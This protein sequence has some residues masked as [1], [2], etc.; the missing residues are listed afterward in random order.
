VSAS[1]V[2]PA[3]DAAATIGRTLECLGAQRSSTPFDVIVVDDGSSDD[4]ASIAE[5]A[6]LEVRVVRQGRR[7]A[8]EARNRGV[9]ESAGEVLAFLDA[10]CFPTPGWLEAGVLALADADVVQGKVLP[11]AGAELGPFDRTLWITENVGLWQTANLFVTREVFDRVGGFEDWL[12]VELGKLMAEDL[13]FGW[14]ATR[15]GARPGFCEGA[16]AHHAI[17]PRGPLGYLD[18]RRRLRYFPPIARKMPELRET[19]F[20]RRL[21]LSPRTAAFDL[22]VAVTAT[23]ALF[24]SPLPLAGWVPYARLAWRERLRWRGR[25][26]AAVTAVVDVAADAVGLI[27]LM[28]GSSRA[29]SLVL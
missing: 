25:R 8:A 13:W 27:E 19:M 15:T 17:L 16:L 24:R 26:G 1:V 12:P 20:V 7:G 10:D 5:S 22:G 28:R 2:I 14:R 29:R 6:D 21:F 11:D 18:E 23:A 4:T 9:R 3:R